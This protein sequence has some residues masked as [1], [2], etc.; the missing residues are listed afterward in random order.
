MFSLFCLF[1]LTNSSSEWQMCLMDKSDQYVNGYNQP[2][3]DMLY[4]NFL[5]QTLFHTLYKYIE[6]NI[7][8]GVANSLCT[9]QSVILVFISPVLKQ[10]VHKQ[11]VMRVHTLFYFLHD[12]IKTYIMITDHRHALTLFLVNSVYVLLMTSESITVETLYNTVNF[13]WSTHKRHSIARW[14]GGVWSVFCEFKGQHIV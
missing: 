4:V 9:Y 6:N 5:L 7:C 1:F 14:K 12:I 13:C 10:W 3:S 11:F 2:Q 8:S